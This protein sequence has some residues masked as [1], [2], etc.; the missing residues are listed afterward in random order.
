MQ[1]IQ[2]ALNPQTTLIKMDHIRCDELL[3]DRIQTDFDMIEQSSIG[4]QHKGFRW[5]MAVKVSQQL[6]CAR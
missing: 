1:P 6:A 2:L 3:L 5:P 4:I